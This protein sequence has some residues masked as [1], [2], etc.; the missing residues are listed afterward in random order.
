M[1]KGL[2]NGRYSTFRQ[3]E[4]E[5]QKLLTKNATTRFLDKGGDAKVAATLIERLR[6]A[7]VSYQVGSDRSALSTVNRWSRYRNNKQSTVKSLTL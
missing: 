6:E 1:V 4:D 2:P 7:I 3:I 5:S